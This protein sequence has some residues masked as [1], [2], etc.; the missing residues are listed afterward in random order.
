MARPK[1]I[2]NMTDHAAMRTITRSGR[3]ISKVKG[4]IARRLQGMLRR[5]VHPDEYL[6]VKVPID[7]E[8]VAICVPSSQGGWDIV[9]VRPDAEGRVDNRLRA[10]A[11]GGLSGIP[12]NTT[13][14]GGNEAETSRLQAY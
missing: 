8:L 14:G 5:G 10:V 11:G 4:K 1:K 12:G 2:I 3:S 13:G 7:N 9:T 6:G